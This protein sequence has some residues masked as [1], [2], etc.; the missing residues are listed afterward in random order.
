M[1][2][3]KK[4]NEKISR[5]VG[6]KDSLSDSDLSNVAGGEGEAYKKL[7]SGL[8]KK[9]GSGGLLISPQGTLSNGGITPKILISESTTPLNPL[10]TNGSI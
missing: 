10:K 9:G 6:A 1:A 2:D 4:D 7:I 3:L 8:A 5:E